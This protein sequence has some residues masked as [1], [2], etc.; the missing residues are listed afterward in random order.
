M[1]LHVYAFGKCIKWEVCEA[2]KLKGRGVEVAYSRTRALFTNRGL[3]RGELPQLQGPGQS[4]RR[5]KDFLALTQQSLLSWP[6]NVVFADKQMHSLC[7][8]NAQFTRG[9]TAH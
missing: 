8:A 2:W 7:F 5:L 4:L 1:I 6:F 3:E 9:R